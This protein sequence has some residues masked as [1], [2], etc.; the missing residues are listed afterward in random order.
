MLAAEE[1]VGTGRQKQP[2]WFMNAADQLQPLLDAKQA[3]HDKV[4]Q[5]NSIASKRAFRKQQRIVKA[6]VEKAKEE[7]IFQLVKDAERARKDGQQRWKCIRQLQITYAGG[8]PKRPTALLKGNGEL[9]RGPEEVKVQW[10]DHFNRV[11]NIPSQFCEE[12]MEEMPTY[13]T[14]LE[15]DNSPT[16]DELLLALGRL[17]RGK[18]GGKTG[19]VPEL[20]GA[21]I[22]DRLLQLIQ[23]MWAQGTVVEDW[24]DAV[25]VPIPKKGDLKLCDNWRG[26]SL[27]DVAGKVFAWILQDRL[28]GIAEKVLPESQCG[29]RKGRGCTDMVFAARQLVEKPGSMTTHSM[30]CLLTSRRPMI[31]FLGWLSGLY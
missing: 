8:R 11:L 22:Q 25:V 6:A 26:I 28:Q 20:P 19:I 3:A 17:R 4:L 7:W 24:R 10:H 18:A 16:H 31:L 5:V 30:S 23:D 9:T 21:D 1:T 12:A 2:D 15:L 27:L 13:P 14:R 29:F